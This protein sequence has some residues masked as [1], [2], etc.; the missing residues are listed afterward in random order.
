[1]YLIH[2]HKYQLKC[3][4]GCL[5]TST[6]E[7][8]AKQIP[9]HPLFCKSE[10][11]RTWNLHE[12]L[13]FEKHIALEKIRRINIW[14]DCFQSI[15]NYDEKWYCRLDIIF[16]RKRWIKLTMNDSRPAHKVKIEIKRCGRAVASTRHCAHVLTQKSK[17]TYIWHL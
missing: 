4:S 9:T 13:Y 11:K 14:W 3:D 15:Q 10:F 8:I 12:T 6:P 17:C 5:N 7:L 16:K 1:M 2:K